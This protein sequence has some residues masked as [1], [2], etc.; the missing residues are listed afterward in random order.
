[1]PSVMSRMTMNMPRV[2]FISI[3]PPGDLDRGPRGERIEL[4]RSK[5]A[6]NDRKRPRQ[7]IV[8]RDQREAHIDR[9]DD[10][11]DCQLSRE[12]GQY[13]QSDITD[14]ENDRHRHQILQLLGDQLLDQGVRSLKRCP[15]ASHDFPPASFRQIASSRF[16]HRSC[17]AWKARGDLHPALQRAGQ[18]L[19]VIMRKAGTT[20]LLTISEVAK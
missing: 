6:V 16:R 8:E 14:D 7:Q 19:R 11:D 9:T 12:A 10:L 15:V 1:M 20:S 3:S 13:V 17:D 4:V 5:A 18:F 2:R